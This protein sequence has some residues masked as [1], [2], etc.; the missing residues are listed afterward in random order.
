[1]ELSGCVAFVTGAKRGIGASIVEALIAAG[2]SRVYAGMRRPSPAEPGA[3]VIPVELDVTNPAQIA[4]AAQDCPDVT[5]LVNNAGLSLGQPLLGTRDLAAAEREMRVNYF[6]TLE[7]CRAFAP[8]LVKNGGA[9]V[10]VLSILSR[11]NM[12]LAGSYSA[13]KAAAFSLTQAVRSELSDKGVLVVGVMPGFVDTDMTK[14]IDAPKVSST[15]VA[16]SVMRALRHGVEDVYP[17][18]AAEIAQEISRDYKA[19]E[20]QFGQIRR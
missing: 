19:V 4:R 3:R 11:T 15:L 8:V 6:G 7:M 18:P 14:G 13:S 16:E 1:M 12:P 20:R 10:N 9:L 17:G 2:A 5:V